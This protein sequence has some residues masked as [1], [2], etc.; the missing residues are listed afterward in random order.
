MNAIGIAIIGVVLLS[1][2]MVFIDRVLNPFLWR[3][4]LKKAAKNKINDGLFPNEKPE[5]G[6]V[7][8]DIAYLKITGP[9]GDTKTL[10]WSDVEEV[11]AFKADLFHI[12]LICLSFKK[13]DGK[14]YYE[15]NEDMV[16][17]R[18]VLEILPK[19]L[20]NYDPGWFSSVAY[21]VFTPNHR[22]IWKKS[23]DETKAL[24]PSVR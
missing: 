6:M 15:I 20:P 3:R 24:A 12:D 23:S 11:H 4:N 21:P 17:Y 2:C 5:N 1:V 14:E 19:R 22:V 16:G 10:K 9:K 18:D 7:Y 13:S 8:D